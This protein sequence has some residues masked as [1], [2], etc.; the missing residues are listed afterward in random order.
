[1]KHDLNPNTMHKDL[2]S[3]SA[4]LSSLR[5]TSPLRESAPNRRRLFQAFLMHGADIDSIHED[6]ADIE[7]W[8]I[9]RMASLRNAPDTHKLDPSL[10]LKTMLRHG[11]NPN[12]R[13][14][15]GTTLWEHILHTVQANIERYGPSIRENNIHCMTPLIILF[16]QY[17]ADQLVRVCTIF[18]K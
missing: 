17:G 18:Y 1:M 12:T 16:L 6:T 7:S 13:A 8:F 4:Y 11:L 3:W 9:G 10:D 5:N 14:R 2:S 15:H